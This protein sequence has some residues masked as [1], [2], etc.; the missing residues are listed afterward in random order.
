MRILI[1]LLFTSVTTLSQE[2]KIILEYINPTIL[3][4]TAKITIETGFSFQKFIVHGQYHDNEF[5]KRISYQEYLDIKRSIIKLENRNEIFDYEPLCLDGGMF[6]LKIDEREYNFYCLSES[7]LSSP[8]KDLL[9]AVKL[10]LKAAK[11]KLE[12][13]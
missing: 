11:I 3:P 2:S 8:R 10:I 4:G 12:N 6:I 9:S 7:D 1:L 13:L 5:E